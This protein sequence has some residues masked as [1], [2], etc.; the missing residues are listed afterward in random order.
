MLVAIAKRPGADVL[1]LGRD[2]EAELARLRAELP[3]GL[4]I[5]QIADQPG[6]VEESVSEFLLK[7]AAALPW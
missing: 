7:F 6:V 4:A 2:L 3:A 5:E 1:A